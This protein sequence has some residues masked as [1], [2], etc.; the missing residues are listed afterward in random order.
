VIYSN[1]ILEKGL[2]KLPALTDNLSW[3]IKHTDVGSAWLTVVNGQG[4]VTNYMRPL[5]MPEIVDNNAQLKIIENMACS[6]R[7]EMLDEELPE[8]APEDEIHLAEVVK[9]FG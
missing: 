6:I 1:R 3:E 4:S 5:P 2:V 7:F 8:F 9:L